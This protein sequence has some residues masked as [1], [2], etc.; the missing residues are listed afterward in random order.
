MSSVISTPLNG[1]G[2]P[3]Y[4]HLCSWIF[5]FHQ[6]MLCCIHKVHCTVSYVSYKD[7]V[8]TLW[9]PTWALMWK[10]WLNTSVKFTEVTSTTRSKSTTSLHQLSISWSNKGLVQWPFWCLQCLSV[11]A[12]A[13]N[14]LS[15]TWPSRRKCMIALIW[16]PIIS[17]GIKEKGLRLLSS[18]L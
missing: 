13:C 18:L 1:W 17:L 7:F 4:N 9:L 3:Y 6:C 11:A 2:L 16:D 8:D 12:V 5:S 10:G 15:T 14:N